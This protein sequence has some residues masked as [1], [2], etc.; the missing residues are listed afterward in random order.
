MQN[1]SYN[2]GETL[3][4]LIRVDASKLCDQLPDNISINVQKVDVA[5]NR[6]VFGAGV[7]PKLKENAIVAHLKI[8]ENASPGVYLIDSARLIWG[9]LNQLEKNQLIKFYPVFFKIQMDGEGL[10]SKEDLSEALDY[11][12][13][14][15]Q[16]FKSS[17]IRTS[18]IE[19][20]D[21]GSKYRVL[22]FA[23]GSK[24]N[25]PQQLEG[26]KIQSLAHGLSHGH[27]LGLVNSTL[28][29]IQI[30]PIQYDEKTARR[31]ADS[32]PGLFVDYC[33]V[34]AVNH[35]DALGHCRE[36]SR[37]IFDLLGFARGQ[38]PREFFCMALDLED[39]SRWFQFDADTYRGNL[40]A[41]ANPVSTSELIEQTLPKIKAGS[42]IRLLL[43]TYSIATADDDLNVSLLRYWSVLEL[44]AKRRVR[45]NEVI[46]DE[47]GDIIIDLQNKPI[48]T[49][50]NCPRVYKHVIYISPKSCASSEYK[51]GVNH[52]LVVGN[53][54]VFASNEQNVERITYWNLVRAVYAMR[55]RVAH[56]GHF[57]P[58]EIDESNAHEARAAHLVLNTPLD[59]VKWLRDTAELAVMCELST[60]P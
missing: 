9:D 52:T 42:F 53:S 49:K 16:R 50:K 17:E 57:S 1:A 15:R 44:V 28:K 12:S 51:N 29:E 39:K 27:L 46:C 59:P 37:R 58:M 6:F 11:L 35:E 8:P 45:D 22:V 34:A 13:K 25:S 4:I 19:K 54:D 23:L 2:A 32:C 26:Y 20:S 18:L 55:N 10:A 43:R 38:R 7:I 31:F 21:T 60:G 40:A 3:E 36:H 48:R 30:P 5:R 14:K 56:E 47:D 24:I 41:D 33:C